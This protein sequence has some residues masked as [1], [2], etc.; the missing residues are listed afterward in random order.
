MVPRFLCEALTVH[1]AL[2]CF[3]N[4]GKSGIY[5]LSDGTK[6]CTL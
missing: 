3:V 5:L 4:V 6:L 1:V 2:G